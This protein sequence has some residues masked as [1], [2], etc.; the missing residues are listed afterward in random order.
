MQA[1][2]VEG[3]T[4]LPANRVRPVMAVGV[5]IV[6]CNKACGRRAIYVGVPAFHVAGF[7]NI[8]Q[9]GVYS[10][11]DSKCPAE[12]AANL[13]R[14][15]GLIKLIDAATGPVD[16]NTG[17]VT[18]ATGIT[19]SNV[20]AIVDGIFKSIPVKLLDKPDLEIVCGWDVFRLYVLALREKNLYHYDAAN[21]DGE[22]VIPGTSIK[23]VA[24]NGLNSTNR[25]FAFRWSNVYLGTDMLNEEEKYEIFYAKEADQVRFV[26]EWKT[27]V[28]FAF[29]DE[30]VEFTLVP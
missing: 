23:L 16:G 27:G 9:E 30:I 28:N 8:T 5:L 14:F 1:H 17:A 15:D 26:A 20:I 4:Q 7:I 18:A 2:Q 3:V 6:V 22:L 29:P 12:R 21:T 10:L 11:T 19:Q 25:L 24:L 13:A